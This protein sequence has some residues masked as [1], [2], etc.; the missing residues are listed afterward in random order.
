[1]KRYKFSYSPPVLALIIAGIVVALSSAALNVVKAINSA[2][3]SYDIVT[4][5]SV[6]IVCAVYLVLAVSMLTSSYYIIDDKYFTLQWGLLK[7]QLEISAITSLKLDS[8]NKKLTVF[9]NEDN[10]FVIRSSSIP[11]ADLV[12]DLIKVNKNISFDFTEEVKKDD[13]K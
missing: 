13:D 11:F 10:F 12:Q 6:F 3:N 2:V 4:L 1:M 9:Y 8:A 7:N 5:L